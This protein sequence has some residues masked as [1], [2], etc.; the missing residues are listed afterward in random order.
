MSIPGNTSE[1]EYT[2]PLLVLLLVSALI[3]A[4]IAGAFELGN[5]EVYYW[6][7]AVYPDYSHFDHPPMVG[8]LIRFFTVNLQ[9]EQEFFLRLF[10]VLAGTLNTWLMFLIG[11]RLKDARTGWIAA[12]LYTASIYGFII[13]GVFILPDAPQSVFWLLA[14]LLMMNI[15]GMEDMQP[16]GNRR[17]IRIGILLGLGLL[18][19]YTVI[20]LWIGFIA[21]LAAYRRSWF[22]KGSFYLMHLIMAA[23]FSLVLLWNIQHDFISFHYQGSRGLILLS[24]LNIDSF[25]T[26]LLG[27]VLYTNPLNFLWIVLTILFIIRKPELRQNPHIR[28]LLLAGIP[29]ILLFL[30]LSL[31]RSTL[32]HWS[33]PG[34]LTLLPLTALWIRNSRSLIMP[35]LS[36]MV[37][38][39]I[40]GISMIQIRT[41]IFR[42]GTL[43]AHAKNSEEADFSLEIYGWEQLGEQFKDLAAK[44]E[45][46]GSIRKSAP[47]LSYRWFPAANLEYYVAKPSGRFVL[48]AG[49]LDAIHKYAWINRI[50]GG[51][52]LNSDAWYI[53]SSRDY[54][55]PSDL[56]GVYY[57]EV[58]PADTIN[59]LRNNKTAYRF[60][61]HRLINM[62]SKPKDPLNP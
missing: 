42:V 8:W 60:F 34:Y 21:Y 15:A 52:R 36:L 50:H 30:G 22:K 28:L 25:L 10:P 44:H 24:S 3:R 49:D 14:L 19:K 41:G 9:F 11:K 16:K 48:A 53:T 47:I 61:V 7:Y 33:G 40:I 46:S 17:M 51:F 26:E 56:P 2:R 20:F 38:L 62:Q 23:F 58:M 43:F 32:P 12:L 54:R 31:F 13:T 1:N 4:F 6:T 35:Y 55:P 27:Q 5:D 59:I 37:M 39:L 29:M 57:Q 45:A 18:S